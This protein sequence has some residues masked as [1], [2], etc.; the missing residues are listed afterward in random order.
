MD[1]SSQRHLWILTAIAERQDVTQRGL[2]KSLGIAL[3]LT[4]LYLKRLTRKGYIKVTTIPAR[5]MRYLLTPRGFAEKTRLTYE[6]MTF[7]LDLCRETR[8]RLRNSMSPLIATGARRFALYG[9]GEAAELAYLT[10]REFGLEPVAV[11]GTNGQR[12]FLG[13]AVRP[14]KDVAA[15]PAD[16]VIVATF[17]QPDRHRETLVRWGVQPDHLIFLDGASAARG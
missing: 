16:R 12:D 4:N 3:G 8:Q 14:L 9:T 5:R 6:Y 2:A 17:D 15:A 11:Y 1:P 13:L 10:L 7:P